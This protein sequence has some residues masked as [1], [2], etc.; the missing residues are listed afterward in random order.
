[1]RFQFHLEFINAFNQVRFA[2]PG[3]RMDI[4]GGTAIAGV[5]LSTYPRRVQLGMKLYF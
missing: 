5:L 4:A 2:N 3:G 1:M